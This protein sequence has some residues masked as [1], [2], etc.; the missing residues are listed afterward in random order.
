MH[1]MH[2]MHMIPLSPQRAS[3]DSQSPS[4]LHR[5]TTSTETYPL[6]PTHHINPASTPTTTH[7]PQPQNLHHHADRLERRDRGKGTS[8]LPS[9]KVANHPARR[10]KL[11]KP[12]DHPLITLLL[13]KQLLAGLFK[14]CDLKVSTQQ[15]KEL[16]EIIGPGKSESHHI[17]SHLPSISTAEHHKALQS[18]ANSD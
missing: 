11:K 6:P 3:K 13:T 1:H 17:T 4:T 16:A 18:S 7:I 8:H 15:L 5:P 2:H 12:P 9:R 14:V 10:L